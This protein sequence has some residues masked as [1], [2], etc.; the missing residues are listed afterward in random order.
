MPFLRAL[1]NHRSPLSVVPSYPSVPEEEEELLQMVLDAVRRFR[2][3]MIDGGR[4]DREHALDDKVKAGLAELGLFGLILPEEH[5]GMG[6]GMRA[7]VRVFNELAWEDQAV[8]TLLGGHLSLA[9]R[10]LMLFG[11]DEQRARWL[12]RMAT[13]ECIGAF[14][15]TE[16]GAGSDFRSLRTRA[17][18]VEGGWRLNGNKLWIT[19]GSD[20]GL[21]LTFARLPGSDRNLAAFLVDAKAEGVVIG[22]REEKMGLHGS[23]TNP[24]DYDNVFVPAA[25]LL[26]EPGQGFT[27]AVEI[28][29]RGRLGW[30]GTCQGTSRR[31][32]H[33]ALHHA[34]Q[35]EQYGVPILKFGMMREHLAVMA[36]DLMALEA[37]TDLIALQFDA[38][39]PDLVCESAAAK[40]FTTEAMCRITDLALQV[41]GGNGYSQEY[42]YERMVRD[43]RVA[44]IF[45]GTNE[46]LRMLIAR[47]VA[48]G[49]DSTEESDWS[50]PKGLDSAW[51]P[52]WQR[53]E[54]DARKLAMDVEGL[55]QTLGDD[56][57]FAESHHRRIA[58]RAISL[59][60]RAALLMRTAAVA[61]TPSETPVLAFS[62]I[63]REREYAAAAAEQADPPDIAMEAAAAALEES[64]S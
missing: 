40:V 46:V 55:L 51:H 64:V 19:N 35:R 17:E 30:S 1:A 48:S 9:A 45:E 2:D 11:N 18:E 62:L 52:F 54:V 12:P 6:L 39:E 34:S 5:G 23:A 49:T 16:P 4:I 32:L 13:G 44:R 28:L 7:Y 37:I 50:P 59:G 26:G 63:R 25:D 22:K 41:A 56:Y 47:Q 57:R 33:E 8:P 43:A 20:A 31:A 60:V 14:A 58:D 38:K 42:P 53:M 27:I 29:N 61:P 15:L 3:D 10:G 21:L 36:A 24:V